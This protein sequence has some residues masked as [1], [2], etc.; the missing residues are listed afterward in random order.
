M[1]NLP[2]AELKE[3]RE[4]LLSVVDNSDSNDI[5]LEQSCGVPAKFWSEAVKNGSLVIFQTQNVKI[6]TVIKHTVNAIMMIDKMLVGVEIP[7]DRPTISILCKS[8]IDEG[9]EIS[10]FLSEVEAEFIQAG[11]ERAN[12]EIKRASEILG[13]NR[14]TLHGRMKKLGIDKEI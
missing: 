12:G 7:P 3:L 4:S 9:K 11:I 1:N 5:S 13:C 14:T 6:L 8:A 10:A 2:V